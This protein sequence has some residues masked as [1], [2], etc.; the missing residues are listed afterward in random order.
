MGERGDL[1]PIKSY[2]R[3][4]FTAIGGCKI[5]L[6][7][8]FLASML[9]LFFEH[10]TNFYLSEIESLISDQLLH[11]LMGNGIGLGPVLPLGWVR[12][13]SSYFIE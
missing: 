3:S 6:T 9:R 10:L 12:W 1:I 8:W 13:W 11:R 5:Q 4:Q 7:K 2:R